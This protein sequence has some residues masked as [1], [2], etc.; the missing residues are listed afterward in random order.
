[1][2]Y[3]GARSASA[4][5]TLRLARGMT[6][7]QLARSAGMSTSG[8]WKAL[9]RERVSRD[10]AAAMAAALGVD[11]RCVLYPPDVLVCDTP[12]E[13]ELAA[14]ERWLKRSRHART[15]DEAA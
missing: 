8:A 2:S 9:T 7:D 10:T 11:E 14:A 5:R 15:G 13:A 3:D 4:I 6:I 12:G 1:M